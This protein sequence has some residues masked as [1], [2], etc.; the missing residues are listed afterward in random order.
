[1]PNKLLSAIAT[2]LNI[3]KTDEQECHCQ[4]VYSI[5]GQ[6][7]LAS[8]WDHT[9]EKGPISIQHFKIRAGEILDAYGE[10]VP[11]IG[12]LV[13]EFKDGW[14]DE[15][16]S[17]YLR[18]GYFY[19]SNYHISPAA[20]KISV[21]EDVVLY[22]GI[23]P[24]KTMFM[25][26]LAFYSNRAKSTAGRVSDMFGLQEQTFEQ[27]LEEILNQSE[28]ESIEWPD[29]SE[30]LRLDPPFSRGY[31]QQDP[32]KDGRISL[33]R[34]GLPNRIF[35]LYRYHDNHYQQK[36]IPSWRLQDYFSN[37]AG[38][39]GEYRRISIALLKRYGTF[40]DIKINK[41]D[42]LI[43]IKLGYR[44]PPSE[45][46]FFKLCSWPVRFN[47]SPK[48]PQVFRR[49]M[50]APVFRLFRHELEKIGYHFVEE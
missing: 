6:M 12:A 11:N 21:S 30:F 36:V 27:Y 24:E 4:I 23:S 45:E 37:N 41:Q 7:A 3:P 48:E 33:A 49:K 44:L 39:Y 2:Q 47:F 16:Y 8:L 38:N 17:V 14:I 9:E 35:V 19:H 1:M 10:L 32:T 13:S 31:W 28:W 20:P 40:P 25:S 5:A 34:Y 46:E 43:E 18:T 26:G 50:A 42:S 15:I 22:R 29:N